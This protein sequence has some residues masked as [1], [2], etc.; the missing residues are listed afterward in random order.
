MKDESKIIRKVFKFAYDFVNKFFDVNHWVFYE[1]FY[2]F[3]EVSTS[4]CYVFYKNKP[5]YG[6]YCGP[7]PT[8]EISFF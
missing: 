3:A 7:K 2:L 6:P 5:K 1:F 8:L 4:D